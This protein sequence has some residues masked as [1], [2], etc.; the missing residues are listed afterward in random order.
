[1]FFLHSRDR[2]RR[3]KIWLP[4]IVWA[5]IILLFSSEAFSGAQT[6]GMLEPLL[7]HLFPLLPTPDIELIHLMIRKLGHF[8]EYFVLSILVLRALRQET[9]HRIA[10]RHIALGL[11]LSALYAISDELHQ[12]LV[13]NRSASIIDVLID[14][15][16]GICGTLWFHLRNAGKD[17][18]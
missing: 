10:R 7:R 11:A 13:P 14:V 4:A 6:S 2:W 1:M 3:L 8:G 18:L 16:G 17:S 15:S 12:A 5:A 9:H